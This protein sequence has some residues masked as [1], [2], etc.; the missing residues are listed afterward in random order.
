MWSWRQT[1]RFQMAMDKTM[2]GLVLLEKL[3][4]EVIKV[5]PISENP[6]VLAKPWWYRNLYD[7]WSQYTKIK[8]AVDTWAEWAELPIGMSESWVMT[9]QTL[10]VEHEPAKLT[11]C[12]VA[13][14]LVFI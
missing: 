12:P 6:M 9:S 8:Y 1:P 13:F 4:H 14:I 11:A 10:D 3:V 7:K 5:K 2:C